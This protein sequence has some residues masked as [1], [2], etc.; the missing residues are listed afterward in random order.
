MFQR[1]PGWLGWWKKWWL[2]PQY[3][4]I[5]NPSCS[6]H[7]LF[8]VAVGHGFSHSYH[9]CGSGAVA[10]LIW[11]GLEVWGSNPV[12]SRLNLNRLAPYSLLSYSYYYL[13]IS[14]LFYSVILILLTVSKNSGAKFLLIFFLV[15]LLS[16]TIFYISSFFISLS[17][18][19]SLSLSSVPGSCSQGAGI[20]DLWWG[21]VSNWWK[22]GTEKLRSIFFFFWYCVGACARVS[23]VRNFWAG[24]GESNYAVFLGG[25]IC[26]MLRW[27]MMTV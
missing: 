22:W 9:S 4:N 3:K 18:C 16:L 12:L 17:L 14:T 25:I 23:E 27:W 15:M 20:S 24:W 21:L 26:C 10:K 2:L 19:L 7:A 5:T 13:V 6:S 1:V 8:H 11:C